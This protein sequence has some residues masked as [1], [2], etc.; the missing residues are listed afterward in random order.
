MT[1]YD[2]TYR[3]DLMLSLAEDGKLTIEVA[4][5][6]ELIAGIERTLSLLRLREWGLQAWRH[7]S[8]RECG[9]HDPSIEQF[10]VDAAFFEQVTPG[11]LEAALRELPKYLNAFRIA[12]QQALT[13]R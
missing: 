4:E 9:G 8:W 5:A 3:G 6:D 11:G 7:P 13:A 2:V 10:V 1:E 12:R